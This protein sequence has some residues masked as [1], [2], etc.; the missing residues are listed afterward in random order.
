M[1]IRTID[2]NQDFPID[3]IE[4]DEFVAILDFSVQD[5]D[6]FRRLLARTRNILWIDHHKT[7]LDKYEGFDLSGLT[8][9]LD[10]SHAG[11][12]LTW[13]H[14][15][16]DSEPPRAVV[17]AE[18]W[19]IWTWKD[20]PE[21][22][23]EEV[24]N[25]CAGMEMYNTDPKVGLWDILFNADMGAESKLQEIMGKGKLVRD[26]VDKYNADYLKD[27]GFET[28]LEGHK[29][30]AL[31]LAKCSSKAFDSVWGDYDVYISFVY[32]GS[33]YTVS[34]Y[35]DNDGKPGS[36]YVDVSEIAK[37]HGGGGHAGASGFQCGCLPF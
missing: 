27:W 2:Y 35:S 21:E 16:P 25:F 32:D 34:L 14:F 20:E 33:Q 15:F 11:C 28:E 12:M 23:Q 4:K 29:C 5:L 22:I 18:L 17:L 26:Y 6:M 10:T 30:I 1:D 3:E 9:V 24:Q 37:R 13:M 8:T 36:S 19:D 7:S 31:N